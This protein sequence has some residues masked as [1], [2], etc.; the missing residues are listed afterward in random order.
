MDSSPQRITRLTPLA[1]VLALIESRVEAVRPEKVLVKDARH[2]TVA[3]DI[4][5]KWPRDST[6]LTDG[7][8]VNAASLADA[9]PY[10]PVPL[11]QSACRVDEGEVMPDGTDAVLPLDAVVMRGD[12][13]E[14]VA[15]VAPGEGVWAAGDNPFPGQPFYD[16]GEQL[17]A[18]DVYVLQGVGVSDISI[19]APRIR[20]ALGGKAASPSL[21]VVQSMLV[22]VISEAGVVVD[23]G[24]TAFD[25]AALNDEPADALFVVGGTG[26]GRH[27]DAVHTLARFG[28]VEIHGVAISP[29]SNAAFGFLRNRA[30]LLFPGRLDAALAVWLLIGRHLV[31]KLAGQTI[32]DRPTTM[33]LKGKITSTIGMTELVAV[34]R[35]GGL[36][37]PLASGHLSPKSLA[38]SNGWIVIPAESEGLPAFSQVAVRPWP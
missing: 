34:A 4:W 18:M 37:E 26:S 25:E 23:G 7:Y 3:E 24:S 16:A 32:K 30:V 35:D 20:L 28:K 19:R 22:R 29:G 15:T 10:M 13:A 38:Y 9:G 21:Q 14:A 33:P 6:A 36:L 27:D 31:A 5:A 2:F 11:S 17:H 1:A 12:R 8:A